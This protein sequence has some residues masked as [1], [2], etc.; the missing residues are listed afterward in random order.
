MLI[1]FVHHDGSR[2]TIA[3]EPGKSLMQAAVSQRVDGILAECGGACSCATCHVI[4]DPE[5][6]ARLGLAGAAEQELLEFALHVTDTSRLACQIRL[7]DAMDGLHVRVPE[8][9]V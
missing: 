2:Q 7:T 4:L 1:T 9:Q 5:W 8:S 6:S 3:A